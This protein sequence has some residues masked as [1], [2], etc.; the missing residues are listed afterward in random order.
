VAQLPDR[1]TLEHVPPNLVRLDMNGDVGG[2]DIN[3]IFERF[4]PWIAGLPFWLFEVNISGLGQVSQEARRIAAER[5]GKTP[6]YA[7]AL[8]GGSLAQRAIATL[9]LKLSELFSGSREVSHAFHKDA[10]AA[11]AWLLEEGR[12]RSSRARR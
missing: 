5:I 2:D 4:E 1:F 6:G 9:V 7:M 3:A 11:R 8:F 10:A 12:R